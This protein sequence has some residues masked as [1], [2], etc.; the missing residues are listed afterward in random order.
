MQLEF[1]LD[2]ARL[3]KAGRLP[4]RDAPGALTLAADRYQQR[5]APGERKVLA[6][7]RAESELDS[8][9]VV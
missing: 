9:A 3:G 5:D 2:F 1:Y 8:A 4:S 7:G 6:N